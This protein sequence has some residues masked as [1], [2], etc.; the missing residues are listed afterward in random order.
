M[1]NY[2]I[3][4]GGHCRSV[5]KIL[6]QKFSKD[7]LQI[8]DLSNEK[9]DKSIMGIE[10]SDIKDI[11]LLKNKVNTNIYCA[12]GDNSIRGKYL[13]LARKLG[14]KTPSLV[15]KNS[16]IDSSAQILQGTF[17]GDFTYVGP[18][19]VLGLDCIVNTGSI[20]EHETVVKDRCQ[21][22]PNATI[23]G[24]CIINENSFIGAGATIIDKIQIAPFTKIGAG[25]TVIKN[26]R[27]GNL[28]WVGTPVKQI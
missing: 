5:I 13:Q 23:C 9:L 6:L 26:I 12:I 15:S 20:V 25:A 19:V 24:R 7:E 27:V 17:I 3:G 1:S 2:I 4:S 10:V 22:S 21:I 28:T 14:F 18:K 11:N 8:I 16:S